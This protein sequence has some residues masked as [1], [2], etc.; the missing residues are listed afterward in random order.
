[1]SNY[2]R[3]G[4]PVINASSTITVKI[5][6][7]LTQ[8]SSLDERNQV[9]L[10][11]NLFWTEAITA[12]LQILTTNVWLEQV[13]ARGGSTK[14]ICIKKNSYIYCELL[15]FYIRVSRMYRSV[16]ATDPIKS[17]S[18]P[19]VTICPPVCRFF[20]LSI[21]SM[22]RLFRFHARKTGIPKQK[23]QSY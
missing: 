22:N 10:Q 17:H 3:A 7:V 8:I 16:C 6:F 13:G 11:L 21:F 12:G 4:R 15:W 1:M 23:L 9:L 19:E 20:R 18:Y 5:G 14:A 2:E